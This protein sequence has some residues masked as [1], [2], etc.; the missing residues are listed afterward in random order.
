MNQANAS[1]RERRGS[2]RRVAKGNTKVTCRRG[3]LG[4]GK[5]LA[6]SLLDIS[7]SGARLRTR[8]SLT[9]GQEVEVSLLPPGC[10]RE[11][12]VAGCIIWCVPTA[13]GTYVAGVRFEKRLDYSA[14]QDL[15]RPPVA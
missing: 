4:L 14:L 12:K 3:T 2:P 1:V 10:V 8:E 13:D 11:H 5:N 6:L 9:L 7:E 15:G